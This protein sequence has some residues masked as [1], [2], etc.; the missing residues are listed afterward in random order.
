VKRPVGKGGKKEPASKTDAT[1][2]SHEDD[3]HIWRLAAET[4]EPLKRGKPRFHPAAEAAKSAPVKKVPP[5]P[6]NAKTTRPEAKLAPTLAPAPSPKATQR[7]APELAAFD[8]NSARKIRIG[9]VEIEARVDL[10]GMHQAE[11]H[12]ALRG[13]LFRS[14][15]RGLRFV[16]VITGKGK[17]TSSG[18]GDDH[19]RERGVLKRNVPRWLEEPDVRSIVV[20]Y[21]AAAIQHGGEGA[22]YVHL[23][24]KDRS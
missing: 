9:R 24:T 12:A 5:A 19:G 16:L 2:D 7:P 13:F 23:R 15:S 11:A 21:T 3:H 1:G 4:I 17:T 14:Q 6:S 22:L 18:N 20:S 8:R 10:H